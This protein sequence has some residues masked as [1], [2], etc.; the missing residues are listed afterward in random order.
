[1]SDK[2]QRVEI[3]DADGGDTY[4]ALL[5]YEHSGVWVQAYYGTIGEAARAALELNVPIFNLTGRHSALSARNRIT[6]DMIE[7]GELG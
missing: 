1:M 5:A 2:L 4:R 6:P 7:S 3:Q